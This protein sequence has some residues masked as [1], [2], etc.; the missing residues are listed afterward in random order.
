MNKNSNHSLT[1]SAFSD[2]SDM[3]SFAVNNSSNIIFLT[4]LKGNI[5]YVNKKF[6]EVTGYEFNEVKGKNPR[7]LNSGRQNRKFFENLWKTIL[8][9]KVWKGEVI[10]KTKSGKI[11][12][13][14]TT[15]TPILSKKGEIINFLAEKEVQVQKALTQSKENFKN[16]FDFAQ[17]TITIHDLSGKML[18]VNKAFYERLGYTYEE[19][20]NLKPEDFDVQETSKKYDERLKEI[21]TKGFTL[22]ETTTVCKTGEKYYTEVISKIIDFEG[23]KAFLNFGRDITEWTKNKFELERSE[24]NYRLLTESLN[25]VVAR[26]SKSGRLLYV[27]P[28]IK[29]FA[30]YEPEEELGEHVSKYIIKKTDL[31]RAS[32]VLTDIFINKNSGTF[33]FLYKSK[34]GNPFPVELSY[35]PVIENN[36]VQYAHLVMRD[37]IERKKLEE[38]LKKAKEEAEDAANMKAAFLANMSHEIRTPMNGILGFTD[39][40]KNPDLSMEKRINYVDIISKSSNHLLNMINDIID[41]SKIDAG[42]INI[43][44]EECKLNFCLLDIYKFFDQMVKEKSAGRVELY[45]NYGV[46]VGEDLIITDE[47]RLR[48]IITNLIGNAAKFTEKGKITVN[49]SIT[50]DNYILISVEDTG[51]GMSENEMSIIFERFRQADDSTTKK[52]GGTGLGLAISKAYVDMLG[53]EIWVESKKGKGSTFYFTIPYKKA[54]IK[55]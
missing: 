45:M 29:T 7:L 43:F 41:I 31:V 39:L 47:T 10:N 33:E 48:Q 25:D 22:F 4:D 35:S 9:G 19:A 28:R 26:I 23:Q 11:F 1:S 40:L 20:M 38:D 49:S 30:G 36:K 14:N 15:V 42:H 21:H 52:Y 50:K 13:D 8:A 53:G 51:I 5:E 55:E 12:W 27:S 16:I 18:T 6:T 3:F 24:K 17:D 34:D 37:N 32:K 46:S 54:K 2:L 44:N